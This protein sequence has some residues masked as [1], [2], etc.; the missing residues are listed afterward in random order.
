[1]DALCQ[2]PVSGVAVRTKSLETSAWRPTSYALAPGAVLDGRFEIAEL[3]NRS[4]MASIFRARDLKSGATVAIKVPLMECES[5]PIA[6]DRFRREETIA[7]RLDHPD[8]VKVIASE[9]PKSRP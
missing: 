2:V 1:M 8:I 7:K 9:E 4:G 6:F 5:D 3:I